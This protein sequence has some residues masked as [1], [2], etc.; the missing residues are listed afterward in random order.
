MMTTLAC[1]H[2]RIQMAEVMPVQAVYGLPDGALQGV[3]DLP[4]SNLTILQTAMQQSR[5]HLQTVFN[6]NARQQANLQE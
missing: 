5:R 1:E 3:Q 6:C 2:N 4:G